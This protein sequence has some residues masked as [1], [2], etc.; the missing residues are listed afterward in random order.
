MKMITLRH[1]GTYTSIFITLFKRVVIGG[2]GRTTCPPSLKKLSFS[3]G[4]RS[5]GAIFTLKYQIDDETILDN[6]V[7]CWDGSQIECRQNSINS[8]NFEAVLCNQVDLIITRWKQQQKISFLSFIFRQEKNNKMTLQ[9]NQSR[10]RKCA[11][12]MWI[13]A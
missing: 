8:A 7:C 4:C 11:F 6:S 10:S 12:C 13:W 1:I 2:V 3:L 9:K 5:W